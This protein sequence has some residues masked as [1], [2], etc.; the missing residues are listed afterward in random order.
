MESKNAEGAN[1]HIEQFVNID[2]QEQESEI[3]NPNQLA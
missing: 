2:G 1:G 3:L